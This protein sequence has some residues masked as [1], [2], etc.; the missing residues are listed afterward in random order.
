MRNL[1]LP[2]LPVIFAISEALVWAALALSIHLDSTQS[3]EG[4][5]PLN[6]QKMNCDCLEDRN[7]LAC[8]CTNILLKRIQ[9]QRDTF[10]HD[11][12]RHVLSF[13]QMKNLLN[14]TWGPR[15]TLRSA[16][17]TVRLIY[18]V[19]VIIADIWSLAFWYSSSRSSSFLGTSSSNC[20]TVCACW[21]KISE[22]LLVLYPWVNT[23]L[24]NHKFVGLSEWSNPQKMSII[25]G[26][27]R[28]IALTLLLSSRG[29]KTWPMM[30]P[31]RMWRF[32]KKVGIGRKCHYV[33]GCRVALWKVACTRR[34]S[35]LKDLLDFELV[36]W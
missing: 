34:R 30:S 5:H 26:R 1:V 15:R 7:S 27:S 14:E 22:R 4:Y 6:H 33:L 9:R 36:Q 31:P 11:T 20:S 3:P 8:A 28:G 21:L 35:N 18:Q 29:P 12:E 25:I 13:L 17:L 10:Q 24:G 19:L 32:E 2:L 16:G 23:F